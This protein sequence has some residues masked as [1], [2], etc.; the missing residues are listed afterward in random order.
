MCVALRIMQV[1]VTLHLLSLL[2]SL[3]RNGPNISTPEEVN[4]GTISI[5]LDGRSAIFCVHGA[6]FIFLQVTHLWMNDVTHA[7]PF[8]IRYPDAL[9]S[10]SVEFLPA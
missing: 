1:N 6:P 4:G 7:L 8:I 10:F 5:L 9:I 2:P 3:T